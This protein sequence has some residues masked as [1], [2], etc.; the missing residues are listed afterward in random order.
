MRILHLYHDLMNL[1]GEYANI[2]ALA[3]ILEENS[4]DYTVD[5]KSLEDEVEINEYDFVFIGAGS[6]ENQKVALAHLLK[7]KDDV[8]KFIDSGKVF[9]ATGNAFEMFGKKI[10]TPSGEYTGLEIFDFVTVR[11]DKKRIT[12]DAIFK[13]GEEMK[14]VGFINK[15]GWTYGVETPLFKVLMGLG[16]NE[17]SGVEGVVKNNFFGTQLTGPILVKNPHFLKYIAEILAGKTLTNNTFS[18]EKAGFEITLNK[19]SDRR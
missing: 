9:L 7:I 13:F 19:L 2:S 12:A 1:Y 6:E 16:N 15:S 8:L 14:L 17:E 4:V 5:K 3:K 18:Y 10:E 11:Q